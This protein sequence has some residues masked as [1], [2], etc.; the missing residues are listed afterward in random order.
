MTEGVDSPQDWFRPMI[1]GETAAKSDQKRHDE[2]AAEVPDSVP[3]GIQSDGDPLAVSSATDPTE[4]GAV[5][6]SSSPAAQG[7]ARAAITEPRQAPPPSHAA[8]DA[9]AE[10]HALHAE[11]QSELETIEETL[12]TATV[13]EA[14]TLTK[15]KRE[16]VDTITHVANI[17]PR[18]QMHADQEHKDAVTREVNELWRPLAAK[19]IDLLSRL[20]EAASHVLSVLH[21]IDELSDEQM[22]VLDRARGVNEMAQYLQA[23]L[24]NSRRYLYA[25][26]A[27]QIGVV[28]AFPA[29][30]QHIPSVETPQPGQERFTKPKAL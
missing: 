24:G 14:M 13:A 29:T 20:E 5:V 25:Y 8:R 21:S 19:R 30:S 6:L 7:A 12:Q 11:S 16:L 26:L 10:H 3:E 27:R 18:L 23:D 22:N 2:A 1:P 4:A 28:Q 9:L 15:R 17:M